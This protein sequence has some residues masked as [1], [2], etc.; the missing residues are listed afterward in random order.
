MRPWK[1]TRK[2][3]NRGLLSK[4]PLSVEQNELEAYPLLLDASRYAAEPVAPTAGDHLVP[5]FLVL[6]E[7]FALRVAR[8]ALSK[9]ISSRRAAG[10]PLHDALR[11]LF[12]HPI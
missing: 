10:F 6:K 4:D 2:L 3:R 11:F 8:G 9:G 5:A 12:G 1:P 7:L